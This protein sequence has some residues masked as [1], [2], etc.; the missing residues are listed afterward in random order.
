MSEIPQGWHSTTLATVAQLKTGPFGSALHKSDYVA[1]GT[2]LINPSHI[3]H[4][5]LQPDEAIS[6]DA[7]ALQ[8]LSEYRLQAGDVV[9]GRRGEMGR[10][11]VV[12]ARAAG[13]VC[14]T[15]SVIVRPSSAILPNYLQRML[16]SPGA[17]ER[18][19]GESVGS[20]MV[21]LNQGVLLGLPVALPPLMEQQ[22]IA[23]KL[24]AVVTRVDACRDRLARVTPLL[25]RF[26]QSVLVAATSGKLTRDWR[27]KCI[28]ADEFVDS[29]QADLPAG[30]RHTT[31]ADV[32][33]EITVGFV[34]KMS[35]EY[36][37]SGVPFLRSMNVREFR[38]DAKGLKFIA[39]AF[40]R[41]IQKSA[42][43]SGDLAIVRSG[44]PGTCCV[45]PP[46]LDGANCSDLVIA[47]PGRDLVS[48]FGC[49][50]INS[51]FGASHVAATQVG[52][53][54][55]HFNVGS[56][57]LMPCPL[58]PVEEQAE[59]V[60]RVEA[61]FAFADRLEARLAKAQAAADRLTPALLAKA[62]RGELVPQDPADE[63][64]AML[65]QRLAASRPVPSAKARRP[66]VSQT[67]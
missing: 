62:F 47:R 27:Q 65:L 8:R 29:S 44:A 31:F 54:Q 23:E 60:R 58:P 12:P 33:S 48:G 67:S 11:A 49:I 21:N 61:L 39:P 5:E 24:D 32:C 55:A 42:L 18:L 66:R 52:V 28:S 15:G 3:K 4:G 35:S 51:S 1:G 63:P 14:G 57:K 46:E 20:T 7:H 40:H 10:C 41:V 2:P 16:S 25:K 34:G 13:W 50:L 22:R 64:A 59:I 56:M 6:I 19:N 36:V 26:R 38:F 45:V 37:D 9:M 43:R 17:V 30:W 53:A